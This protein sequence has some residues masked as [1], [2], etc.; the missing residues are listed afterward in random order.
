M[1]IYTEVYEVVKPSTRISDF[2]APTTAYLET[3]ALITGYLEYYDTGF[4]KWLGLGGKPIELRV[5]K[6]DGTTLTLTT[7]TT[8]DGYFEFSVPLDQLGTWT[9]IVEFY[10]DESY[11]GSSAGC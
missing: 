10:E 2:S 7:T 5:T 1:P 6:P 3:S 11:L 8:A 9:W 4:K